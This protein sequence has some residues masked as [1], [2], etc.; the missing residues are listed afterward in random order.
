MRFAGPSRW[1]RS[2]LVLGV[3]CHPLNRQRLYWRALRRVHISPGSM[4]SISCE[5]G[6]LGRRHYVRGISG[7]AERVPC[8]VSMLG[9]GEKVVCEVSGVQSVYGRTRLGR[10]QQHMC[11]GIIATLW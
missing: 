3:D 4:E 11:G 7:A 10:A 8:N 5:L 6:F 2:T 9:L 1:E